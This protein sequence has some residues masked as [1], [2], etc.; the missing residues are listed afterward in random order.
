M[1]VVPSILSRWYKF[2]GLY[3]GLVFFQSEGAYAIQRKII[4][5]EFENDSI[6]G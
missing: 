6:A 1:G 5:L 4:E 3:N 2:M